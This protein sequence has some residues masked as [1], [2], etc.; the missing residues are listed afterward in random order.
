MFYDCLTPVQ[1]DT[2]VIDVTIANNR[3]VP[4]TLNLP[5]G[6]VRVP[7]PASSS[8]ATADLP[9]NGANTAQTANV[10]IIDGTTTAR[11][12]LP[13]KGLPNRL[14]LYPN[15]ALFFASRAESTLLDALPSTL[16]GATA[17]SMSNQLA[18]LSHTADNLRCLN[19]TLSAVTGGPVD[20]VSSARTGVR[21]AIDCLN[22]LVRPAVSAEQREV[23]SSVLT[24]LSA[25]NSLYNGFDQLRT[26]ATGTGVQTVQVLTSGPGGA[27]A[28]LPVP[29]AAARV[30]AAPVPAAAARVPAA[31]VPA[32]ARATATATTEPVYPTT[33]RPPLPR[34]L[35]TAT[36]TTL[37]ID[38]PSAI[39]GDAVTLTATVTPSAV[40]A[41]LF[42]GDGVRIGPVRISGGTV[43][44]QWYPRSSGTVTAV[45]IPGDESD[46]LP[47]TSATTSY[48]V[49]QPTSQ[50]P[51]PAQ[52]VQQP[53]VQQQQLAQIEQT[54]NRQPQIQQQSVR[55]A[56]VTQD[57]Q[58]PSARSSR[59][60]GR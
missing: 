31:P 35:P 40:G 60:G 45:F 47:S 21:T 49:T 44:T 57:P 12:R 28:V 13:V 42:K 19:S 56:P 30:P 52:T 58:Q 24:A 7:D 38:P 14:L 1:G 17:S 18:G 41:V 6:A 26:V 48:T 54:Q 11:L 33:T 37:T 2:S 53:T 16:G 34:P 22:N 43:S 9:S 59:S 3:A 10:E 29:A 36:S 15:P 20:L 8:N 51:T 55:E 4:Y 25:Q 23:I 27:S 39:L 46:F 32:A 5:S 50:P